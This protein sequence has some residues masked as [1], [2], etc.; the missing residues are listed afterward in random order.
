VPA[1]YVLNVTEDGVLDPT[2][3]VQISIHGAQAITDGWDYSEKSGM[4]VIFMEE[5]TKIGVEAVI[6]EARRVT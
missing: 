1:P 5:F 3:T 4:R 2:R 6:E